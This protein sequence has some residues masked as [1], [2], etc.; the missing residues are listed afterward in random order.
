MRRQGFEPDFRPAATL[1][2]AVTRIGALTGSAPEQTRGEKR[3][4]LALRDALGLDIATVETNAVLGAAIADRLDLNWQPEVYVESTK[5]TLEGVN[6]LLRGASIAYQRGSLRALAANVPQGLAGPEWSAFQPPFS[7]I[8]AVTR[9]S[10]LTDSGPE[11]LGPGSKE[12]KS[13]LINLARKLLPELEQDGLSKTQLGGAIARELG[14]PWGDEFISTGETIRLTGLTVILA[15]AERRLGRLGTAYAEGLTP[16]GEGA[17]L[18][19]AL[20]QRLLRTGEQRWDG[21]EKT[22]WLRDEGTRQENQMEWPGFYFEFRGRD[23]LNSTFRPN[24]DPPTLRYGN[25]AFDYALNHVWDL[26]AHT[27]EQHLPVTGVTRALEDQVQLNDVEAIRACVAEQGLGF[28]ILSGR[29]VMDEDGSFK[30]WHDRFKPKPSAASNTGFSRTRKAAFEPLTVEAYWIANTP[31]L[32]AAICTGA[33]KP[34]QQGRQAGGAPRRDKFRMG[35][36]PARAA[37]RVAE[38]DW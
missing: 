9:I 12:H 31:A 6:A 17:A 8:E 36:Q 20:W 16:A 4:L 32:D 23:V 25:T 13:V 38:R 3:A 22:N 14:V 24:P 27:A 35:L 2:E 34:Q 10:A 21:R 29:G 37:L 30:A 26:K 15:G 28:L 19:D 33:L 11:W 7:K 18:V 5:L 1:G